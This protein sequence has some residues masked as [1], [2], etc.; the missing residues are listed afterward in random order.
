[1]L[2]EE[3]A[4]LPHAMENPLGEF[5]AFEVTTHLVCDLTPERL[6]ASLVNPRVANDRKL[7]RFRRDEDQHAVFLARLAHPQLNERGLGR[8]Q[9]FINRLVANENA[10]FARGF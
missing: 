1:M 5:P 4:G 9:R 6:P 7:V 8:S 2:S 3:V 10:D